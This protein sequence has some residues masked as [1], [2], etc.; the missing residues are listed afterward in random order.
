ML[1][2]KLSLNEYNTRRVQK[3]AEFSLFE[4]IKNPK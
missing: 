3:Q 4:K 1:L 2:Y